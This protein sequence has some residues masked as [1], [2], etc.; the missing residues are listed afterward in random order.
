MGSPN[1]KT[2]FHSH[3]SLQVVFE[4]FHV[5]LF[6]QRQPVPVDDHPEKD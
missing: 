3:A 4:T 2:E 6:R 5:G 1:E